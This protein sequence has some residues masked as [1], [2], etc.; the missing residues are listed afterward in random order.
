MVSD[1]AVVLVYWRA[2]EERQLQ[3]KI[4]FVGACVL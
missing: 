3:A 2:G 1:G 4:A